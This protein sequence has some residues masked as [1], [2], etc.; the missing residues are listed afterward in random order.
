[1]SGTRSFCGKGGGRDQLSYNPSSDAGKGLDDKDVILM[2]V[3]MKLVSE[4]VSGAEIC[5]SGLGLEEGENCT[6]YYHL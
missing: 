5:R 6:D 4:Q 2:F 1:M 3:N